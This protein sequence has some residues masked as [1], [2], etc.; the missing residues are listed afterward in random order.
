MARFVKHFY[1][2]QHDSSIEDQINDYAERNNLT[3]ITIAPLY[4]NGI[5]VLFE[6]GDD[7]NGDL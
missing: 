5:Y 4:Q 1:E 6:E 7:N 2:W 3:I